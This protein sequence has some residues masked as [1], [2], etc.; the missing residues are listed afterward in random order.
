MRILL[1]L[2]LIC[3]SLGCGGDTSVSL[4][5]DPII[6]SQNEVPSPTLDE[7]GSE[8]LFDDF[9]AVALKLV[10][11]NVVGGNQ[12]SITGDEIYAQAKITMISIIVISILLGIFVAYLITRSITSSLN[13]TNSEISTTLLRPSENL[14]V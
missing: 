12:A 7:G 11:I 14:S 8:V 10:K 6:D 1:S 5:Q 2:S 9:S 3:W 4:S 13:P